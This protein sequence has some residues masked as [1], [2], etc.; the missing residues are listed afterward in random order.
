[1]YGSIK[2]P[3]EAAAKGAFFCTKIK[4]FQNSYK[5]CAKKFGN[6]SC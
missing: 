1:M 4:I 5:L 3:Q 2:M 6:K